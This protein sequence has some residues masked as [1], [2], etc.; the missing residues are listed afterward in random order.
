MAFQL[1]PSRRATPAA[2]V[3]AVAGHI[4]THA[5]TEGDFDT[6]FIVM[7]ASS[8]QLT[9]S[10]RATERIYTQKEEVEFQLTPSRRATVQRESGRVHREIS[11]HA[12][13]EGDRF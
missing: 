5:L 2:I 9:P 4:S 10:R 11:T 1:T 7:F 3:A 8:F 13:T 12:L 6:G